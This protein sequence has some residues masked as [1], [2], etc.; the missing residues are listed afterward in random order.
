M[1]YNQERAISIRQ[2]LWDHTVDGASTVPWAEV[3]RQFGVTGEAV[4]QM[5]ARCGIA[6]K[7]VAPSVVRTCPSCGDVLVWQGATGPAITRQCRSC[8][9]ASR[10]AAPIILRCTSCD[11]EFERKG[12]LLSAYKRNLKMKPDRKEVYC[13]ACAVQARMFLRSAKG[14]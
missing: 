8:F 13:P 9:L 6:V 12:S 4:R 14:T 11:Q 3:A 2:Y 7:T 5:A 10:R 1:S